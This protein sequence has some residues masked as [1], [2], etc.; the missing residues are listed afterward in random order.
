VSE[1]RATTCDISFAMSVESLPLF[2]I[3]EALHHTPHSDAQE[4]HELGR[5]TLDHR[6]TIYRAAAARVPQRRGSARRDNERAG[7]SITRM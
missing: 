5:P 7:V 2:D 4:S 3:E 1:H 6:V